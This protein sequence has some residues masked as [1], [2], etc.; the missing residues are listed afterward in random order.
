MLHE[1]TAKA[2]TRATGGR[3]LALQHGEAPRAVRVCLGAVDDIH[4]LQA[5]LEVLAEVAAQKPAP[6]RAVV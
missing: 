4:T 6:E 2:A 3:I 5:G 1:V